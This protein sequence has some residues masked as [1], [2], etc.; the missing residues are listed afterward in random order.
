MLTS[1]LINN[2]SINNYL[3]Y[4]HTHQKNIRKVFNK[5][6]GSKLSKKNFSLDGCSAPQYSFKIKSIS[7]ALNN[8]IKSYKDGYDYSEEVKT[9]INSVLENPEYIGGTESFDTKV[10]KASKGKIFCKSGAEG[11]F[12]FIDIQKE[13]SGVIKITDGNE[14][15]IPISIINIF[16]KLKVMSRVELKNLE[17]KE[18]FVLQNHAGRN[19]GRII[20]TMK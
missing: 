9:L 4:N 2:Q 13:I 5:F 17:K 19:I 11:V 3:D 10:M 1:C 16:K 8:L 7:K 14:R 18:K 12:L 6:T 15:A 20:L